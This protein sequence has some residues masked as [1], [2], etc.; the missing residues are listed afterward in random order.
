[1]RTRTPLEFRPMQDRVLWIDAYIWSTIMGYM[2]YGCTCSLI[3]LLPTSLR[4]PCDS[5]CCVLG[6]VGQL[7]HSNLSF[8]SHAAHTVVLNGYSRSL[9]RH[10]WVLLEATLFYSPWWHQDT[11]KVCF[12]DMISPHFFLT[13]KLAKSM[14]IGM[15][16]YICVMDVPSGSET[17]LWR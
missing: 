11:P 1:M 14:S 9:S 2:G 16:I 4:C 12:A 10:G 3:C 17:L 5:R 8:L 6:E 15:D 13:S 7:I